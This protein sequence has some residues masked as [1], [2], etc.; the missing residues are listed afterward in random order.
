M[1]KSYLRLVQQV[2]QV[3][4]AVLT[5]RVATLEW[6]IGSFPFAVTASVTIKSEKRHRLAGIFSKYCPLSG[7]MTALTAPVVN[8]LS[9]LIVEFFARADSFQYV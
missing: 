2:K 6:A 8:R 3:R 5:Q 7:R 9:F 1:I 4:A